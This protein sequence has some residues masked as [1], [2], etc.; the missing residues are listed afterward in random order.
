MEKRKRF[1]INI[2]YFTLILIIGFISLKYLFPIVSPFVFAFIISSLLQKPITFVSAKT[3]LSRKVSAIILIL[4]ILLLIS[5]F[6]FLIGN[7]VANNIESFISFVAKKIENLPEIIENVKQGI[8]NLTSGLPAI[9]QTKIKEYTNNFFNLFLS[10]EGG[11]TNSPLNSVFDWAKKIPSIFL[12]VIIGIISTAFFSI[13]YQKITNFIIRQLSP[14]H[15]NTLLAIKKIFFSTILKLIK[16]YSILMLITFAQIA[17][18]FYLMKIFN[19]YK[20]DYII[21]LSALI[22]IIDIVPILGTGTILIPWAV[23]AIV[24]GNTKMGIFLLVGYLIIAIARNILEP[25][26]IGNQVGASPI[27]TLLFMYI[28][29]KLFGVVGLI[30]LPM[31]VIIIKILSD[32]GKIRIWK[33]E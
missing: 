9:I 2:M 14:K 3:K 20:T 23:Y 11:I 15:Q 22:A 32:S 21:L 24:V 7:T 17:A 5:T 6:L 29:L 19:V 25:K 10:P 27:V 13:D 1:L 18:M 16:S 4:V 12:A 33:T 26:I 30:V 8:L 28:G 31:I